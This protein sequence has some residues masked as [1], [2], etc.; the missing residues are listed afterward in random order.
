MS[1]CGS[2]LS[3]HPGKGSLRSHSA[4]CANGRHW[5][6]LKP[7]R[8]SC[9]APSTWKEP[10]RVK[11]WRIWDTQAHVVV[12]SFRVSPTR[13]INCAGLL[14]TGETKFG[15]IQVWPRVVTKFG[16]TKF[17]QDQVWPDQVWPR[18]S[19]ARPSLAKTKF[20][21]TKFGQDQVWPDQV[22][23]NQ[24]SPCFCEGVAS[25]RPATPSQTR[26]MSAFRFNGPS[27]GASPAEGRRCST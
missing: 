24:Y 3:A 17:G 1:H 19:L 6:A 16:Q 27:C 9:L 14:L 12:E 8:R 22:R 5:G 21:Q 2:R 7:I 10:P 11:R 13:P 4:S 18:P 26:L 20:G 23:D 25:R 15:Q